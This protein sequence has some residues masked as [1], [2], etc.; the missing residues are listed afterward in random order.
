MQVVFDPATTI[1]RSPA[2]KIRDMSTKHFAWTYFVL[3]E[4]ILY[5]IHAM[6][7]LSFDDYSQCAVTPVSCANLIFVVPS[8][9]YLNRSIAYPTFQTNSRAR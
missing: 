3:C 5:P 7:S 8:R 1:R 6:V 2:C 4:Y 9:R